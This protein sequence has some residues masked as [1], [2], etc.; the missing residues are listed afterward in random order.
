MKEV[1]LKFIEI[2]VDETRKRLMRVGAKLV[3]SGELKMT[4]FIKEGFDRKDSTKQCL[5][6]RQ[7]HNDV[8]V[9]YKTPACSTSKATSRQE[10]ELIVDDY[11]KAVALFEQLGFSSDDP[12]VKHREHYELGDW[13]YEIDTVPGI[14]TYLE[15]EA[16]SDEQLLEACSVLG[17]NF[18]EGKKGTIFEIYS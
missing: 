7:E 11:N 9:T 14:P 1:E 17:L 13:H 10:T 16:G 6:V 3:S 12:F 2:D 18:S 5:R 8:R 4:T 15:V